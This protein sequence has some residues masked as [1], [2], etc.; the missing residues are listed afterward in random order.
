MAARTERLIVGAVTL[1]VCGEIVHEQRHV[2]WVGVGV[3]LRARVR[4]RIG[5]GLGLGLGS[6]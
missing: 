4:V 1:P 5:I 3:G 2:L 6:G